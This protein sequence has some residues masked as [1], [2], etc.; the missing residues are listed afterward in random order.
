[1]GDQRDGTK[2]VRYSASSLAD[3]HHSVLNFWR[4]PIQA[5]AH[6]LGIASEQAI[7]VLDM[8]SEL[9]G[10]IPTAGPGL[11]AA[12]KTLVSIWKAVQAV[13]V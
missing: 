10:L 11:E 6:G 8:S 3:T 9:F 5:V 1:M 12:A 7:Q 4:I 2:L 13:E